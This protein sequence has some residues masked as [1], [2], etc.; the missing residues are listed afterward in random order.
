MTMNTTLHGSTHV[1]ASGVVVSGQIGNKVNGGGGSHVKRPMNA[2]MVSVKLD[3][4]ITVTLTLANS[5]TLIIL[6]A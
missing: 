1:P 3:N 6:F 2:F 4:S 5:I